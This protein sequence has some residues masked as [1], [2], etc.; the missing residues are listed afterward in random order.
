VTRTAL[1]LA[2]SAGGT[3]P[4]PKSRRPQHCGQVATVNAAGET[5]TCCALQVAGVGTR[6]R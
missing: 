4:P 6:R 1:E 2:R 3:R 5:S